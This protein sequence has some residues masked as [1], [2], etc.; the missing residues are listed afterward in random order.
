LKNFSFI[1]LFLGINS[2]A[3]TS[4]S[5]TNDILTTVKFR[6]GIYRSFEEFKT[7]APS[8]TEGFSIV[9]K[10]GA[11]KLEFEKGRKVKGIFGFSDGDTL[12]INNSRSYHDGGPFVKILIRGP[13]MYFEDFDSKAGVYGAYVYYGYGSLAN[14]GSIIAGSI[15]LA[16]A[17]KNSGWII[18]MPDGT[19]DGILLDKANLKS[20]L[21]EN[22]PALFDEFMQEENQKQLETLF[23]YVLKFNSLSKKE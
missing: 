1:L 7:N 15:A 9:N 3:Q 16:Q 10:R 21:K 18:Y 23:K 20:I 17:S 22:N 4:D 5:L 11:Y 12:Y 8:A 19:G 14:A 2:F 13:I 6:R